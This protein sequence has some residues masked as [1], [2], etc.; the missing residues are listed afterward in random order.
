MKR[1]PEFTYNTLE[2]TCKR[3]AELEFAYETAEGPEA[4]QKALLDILFAPW[5]VHTP[6]LA[7]LMRRDKK[8]KES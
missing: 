2:E 4:R 7:E 8:S 1:F 5:E 3:K 6:I